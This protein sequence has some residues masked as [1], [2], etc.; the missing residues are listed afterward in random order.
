MS[1][2]LPRVTCDELVRVLKRAGFLPK[3]QKGNHLTLWREADK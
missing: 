1:D 2:K 3:R